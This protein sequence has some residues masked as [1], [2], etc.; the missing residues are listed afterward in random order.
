[1]V[2][3]AKYHITN[4]ATS[5][6][7]DIWDYTTGNWSERQAEKYYNELIGACKQI[8]ENPK[9]GKEYFEVEIELLGLKTG[10]HIIFYETIG[11][12]EVKIIRILHERMDLENRIGE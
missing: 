11:K 8:A 2:K 3:M 9:I 5:D 7:L 10:R 4:K 1:M 12:N 6:L